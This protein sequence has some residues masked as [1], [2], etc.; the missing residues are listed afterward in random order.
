MSNQGEPHEAVRLEVMVDYVSMLESLKAT[1]ARL[2]KEEYNGI[3]SV[4]GVLRPTPS[5][6]SGLRM[7]N[8]LFSVKDGR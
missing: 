2:H 1:R 4:P 7:V 6:F 5:Y 8:T 3:D